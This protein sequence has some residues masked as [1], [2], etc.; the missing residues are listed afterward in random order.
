MM[1]S[2]LVDGCGRTDGAASP[3]AEVRHVGTVGVVSAAIWY[4][5]VSGALIGGL[6]SRVAAWRTSRQ[7]IPYDGPAESRVVE[8]ARSVP[9]RAAL[10]GLGAD[11]FTHHDRRAE[12]SALLSA[13]P[14]GVPTGASP[15]VSAH[16]AAETLPAEIEED[17]RTVADLFA[18]RELYPGA[19]GWEERDDAIHSLVRVVQK[20]SVTR[21]AVHAG[22]MGVATGVVTW[23]LAGVDRVG[24]EGWALAAAILLISSSLVIAAVDHDTL[25]LDTPTLALAGGGAWMCAVFC[26]WGRGDDLSLRVGVFVALAWSGC[27]VLVNLIYKVL[28]GI[29]G[30]GF[31]DVLITLVAAGVPV[32]LSGEPLVGFT[33]IVAAMVLALLWQ[34]PKL[35]LK[36]IGGRDA[37]ALGP[38]LGSGWIVSWVVLRA[39]GVA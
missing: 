12:W 13:L 9:G 24:G 10:C 27:F 11:V 15:L 20:P 33:G 25:F 14:A 19:S 5:S 31:G 16:G 37:F 4:L 1:M 17:V 39:L 21:T 29:T 26:S 35:V 32:V 36:R 38:F 18:E 8:W 6:L 28:R 7:P 22:V 30:M 23:L 3:R 34:L 2:G